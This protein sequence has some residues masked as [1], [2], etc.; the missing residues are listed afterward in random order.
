MVGKIIGNYQLT[1]ELGYGSL[2]VVYRGHH[3]HQARDIV[4]KEIPLA[5]FPVSTRVQ[6]KARFR[7]EAFIQAQLDHPG[8][9]H[10]YESFAKGDNYYLVMEYIQAISLREL[11]ESQ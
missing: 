4:I 1:E 7:R 6:L 11:L 3:I 5:Y 10:L 2:G 8:I 9:V